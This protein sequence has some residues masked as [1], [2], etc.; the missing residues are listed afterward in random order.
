MPQAA[1]ELSISVL[2][3]RIQG[4]GIGLNTECL[5]GMTDFRPGGGTSCTLLNM[6]DLLGVEQASAAYSKILWVK[7][8]P[9]HGENRIGIAVAQPETVMEIPFSRIKP[10]PRIV[11]VSCRR[12]GFVAVACLEAELVIIADVRKMIGKQ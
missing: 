1:G 4:V 7:H 9:A 10:L 2:L 11:E 3:V 6:H 5:T 8:A 12:G